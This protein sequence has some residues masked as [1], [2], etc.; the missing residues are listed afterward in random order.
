VTVV[1]V[2]ALA[3]APDALA[4]AARLPWP[5]AAPEAE[6]ALAEHAADLSAADRRAWAVDRALPALAG[7]LPLPADAMRTLLHEVRAAAGSAHG[8]VAL[9]HARGLY[10]RRE[11]AGAEA[12]YRGIAGDSALWPQS[13]RERAWTLLLL[14][15]ADE[16]MGATVSLRAPWFQSDDH[17]EARLLA[18]TVLVRRC[19]WAEAR[20]TIDALASQE[21]PSVHDDAAAA[22][23]AGTREPALAAAA[24]S[25]LVARVRSALATAAADPSLSPRV[26]AI[27]QLG[28]R[29]AAGALRAAA[30]DAREA[31]ERALRLRYDALRGER[32]AAEAG[33]AAKPP[34]PAPLVPLG[35]DEVAWRFDGTWWRDE[36]GSYRYETAD[37]CPEAR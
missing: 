8:L 20:E 12:Q 10:G 37:A 2:V 5:L 35:D 33:R 31:K 26:A 30:D 28:M 16:A 21:V 24:A 4:T 23:L 7:E 11:L 14:G 9:Q 13:L 36:L 6:A 22:V 27:R 1:L 17:A 34:R 32:A 19:R 18:A 3:A 29:L 25:P 15:R